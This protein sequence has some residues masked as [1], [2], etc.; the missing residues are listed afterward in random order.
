VDIGPESS[1]FAKQAVRCI[2]LNLMDS[3]ITNFRTQIRT[4]INA[5]Q[6]GLQM[7]N[8]RA[9]WLAPNMVTGD[10]GPKIDKLYEFMELVHGCEADVRTKSL[11]IEPKH[12][13]RLRI[14]ARKIIEDATTVG[15]N[16]EPAR[17][18]FGEEIDEERR[19]ELLCWIQMPT[20]D[21]ELDDSGSHPVPGIDGSAS[22]ATEEESDTD[23]DIEFEEVKGFFTEGIEEFNQKNYTEAQSYLQQGVQL[24]EKPTL[25]RRQLVKLADIK[26]K[27]AT[28]FYH[29]P[30]LKEAEARLRAIAHER[31]HEYET[32][33]GAIRRCDASHLLAG[34]LL[35]QGRY[36]DA[37]EFCSQSATGRARVLGKDHLDTYESL[38][39]MSQIFEANGQK[40]RAKVYWKMI[41]ADVASKLV[42][43]KDEF[44]DMEQK[45]SASL[46]ASETHRT[47]PITGDSTG[48][49]HSTSDTQSATSTNGADTVSTT[50]PNPLTFS[51]TSSSRLSRQ[52]TLPSSLER[53][54]TAVPTSLPRVGTSIPVITGRPASMPS[55]PSVPDDS[56][57][58]KSARKGILRRFRTSGPSAIKST[59]SERSITDEEGH[60]SSTSSEVGQLTPFKVI[61]SSEKAYNRYMEFI[62]QLKEED[63]IRDDDGDKEPRWPGLQ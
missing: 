37:E 41:P 52:K 47:T 46:D 34:V 43:V 49:S 62:R 60:Q 12:L 33:E 18:D 56:A 19:D 28:C 22:N 48:R 21:G 10:L 31:I 38:S 30:N 57:P 61:N 32:K 42:K 59:S 39:L 44:P 36:S 9:A 25:K 26:L 5:L 13:T 8:L 45:P 24:A 40:L 58:R 6:M 27:I 50:K 54:S 3:E 63:N 16:S 15:V 1:A 23:F 29:S 51:P 7:V 35:R 14:S 20:F 11:G 4:H 55:A 53:A 17:S 2:K